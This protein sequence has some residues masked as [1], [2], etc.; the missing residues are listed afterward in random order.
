MEFIAGTMIKTIGIDFTLK[1]IS[2]LTASSQGIYSLIKNINSCASPDISLIL[3]QLDLEVN[4]K[5]LESLI[6][7]LASDIRKHHSHTLA[8]CVQELKNCVEQI[9]NQLIQ[10]EFRVNYNG[11]LWFFRS[12]R[13][14]GFD[15][16]IA[17]ISVLKMKLDNRKQLLFDVIKINN[18]LSLDIS[19]TGRITEIEDDNKPTYH[20]LDM[21]IINKSIINN[22]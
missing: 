3:Q 20:D 21:T 9:E 13:S 14:Y 12:I 10:I 22:I 16:I 2:T 4:I 11:S 15:D 5:I 1:C 6:R 17:N 7:E 18:H 8:L 19:D